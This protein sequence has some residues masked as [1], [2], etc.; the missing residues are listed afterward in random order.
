M[1][2]CK[3]ILSE[4]I[5]PLNSFAVYNLIEKESTEQS[6]LGTVPKSI[7]SA[8]ATLT[9]RLLLLRSQYTI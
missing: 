2:T 4:L 3:Y 6:S 9:N 7:D 1:P 5:N 8:F